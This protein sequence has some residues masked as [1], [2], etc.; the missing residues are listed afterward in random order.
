[1]RFYSLEKLINL[2]DGYRKLIKIDQHSLLLLQ[3]DG[4]VYLIEAFC[5]HRGHGLVEASVNGSTLRCPLHSYEFDLGSGLLTKS[6]EEPCRN[7]QR[8][9]PV[10]E[11]NEVGVLL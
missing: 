10:F 11:A 3:V 6:T 9:D 1:M 4:E 8:Y 2:H 5:P 7:L